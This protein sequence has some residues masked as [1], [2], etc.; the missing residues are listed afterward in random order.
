MR[1][2]YRVLKWFQFQM[3]TMRGISP[4]MTI[5]FGILRGGKKEKKNPEH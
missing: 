5:Y 2:L 1:A 4:C 3:Q